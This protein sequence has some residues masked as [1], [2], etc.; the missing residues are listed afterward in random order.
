MKISRQS[1][2]VSGWPI[3]YEVTGAGEPV[4]LVH[5]LA[6]STRIWYRNVSELAECY[7]V[8]LIDLPGFGAMRALH[9]QFNLTQSGAWLDAWMRAVGLEAA[10]LVGHSMGGYVCM[11]LAALQPEKVRRLVLVDSLGVP[12][13]LPMSRLRYA[14]LK[15]IVRTHP[16]FWPCIHFDYWRAGPR[17]IGR[18]ARQIVELDAAPVIA[19]VRTPTLLI[20]GEHDDLVP[21]SLGRRLHEQLVGSRLLV[22]PRT[23]HFPMYE[24]PHEFNHM[25]MAFLQGEAPER[26]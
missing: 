6:E 2:E 16:S 9:Q 3:H 12:F 5:G 21:L 19:A 4:V 26:P 18:A 13:D 15:A 10:S 7:R 25:L 22:V 20:W 14:A 1:I 17:M 11:A 24:W 8:Y 23:N